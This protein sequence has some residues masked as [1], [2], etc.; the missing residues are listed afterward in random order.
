FQTTA[1]PASFPVGGVVMN[2]VTKSGGNDLK[3]TVY[4]NTQAGQFN[5]LNDELRSLG[6]KATS[7]STGSYDVDASVGGPI[8]RDKI[9]FFG[10]AR[11]YSFSGL[12]AISF[13]L[14]GRQS[15]DSVRRWDFFE[16]ATF[17]LNPTNKLVVGNVHDTLL[18]PYR[19]DSQSFYTTEANILNYYTPNY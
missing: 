15:F 2:T 8:R 6:V 18:R 9:W 12:V 13:M 1:I 11:F 14:D 10:A 7:G 5:N 3:G 16:K 17:N 4:A 19:R